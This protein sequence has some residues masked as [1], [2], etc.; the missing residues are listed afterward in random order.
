MFLWEIKESDMGI[1]SNM[2]RGDCNSSASSLCSFTTTPTLRPRIHLLKLSAIVDWAETSV[3]NQASFALRFTDIILVAVKRGHA[4]ELADHVTD[5][6]IGHNGVT[7]NLVARNVCVNT[8]AHNCAFHINNRLFI[9][10][11]GRQIDV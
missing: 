7:I 8:S 9:L 6:V 2:E 5:L 11:G 10:E 4:A 3:R 1:A